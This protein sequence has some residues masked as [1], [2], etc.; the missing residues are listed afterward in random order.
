[1]IEC[2]N[3]HSTS[4]FQT[5]TTTTKTIQY[6]IK[7]IVESMNT[8]I[9][10]HFEASSFYFILLYLDLHF[11]C[12]CILDVCVCCRIPGKTTNKP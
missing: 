8:F 6:S 1:M 11:I 3:L 2:T 5:E 10:T 4:K 12:V 9:S 7:G